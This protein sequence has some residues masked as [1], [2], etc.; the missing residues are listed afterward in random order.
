MRGFSKAAALLSSVYA[1]ASVASNLDVVKSDK[2]PDFIIKYNE[3]DASVVFQISDPIAPGVIIPPLKLQVG[4]TQEP[5][6]QSDIRLGGQTVSSRWIED[7]EIGSGFLDAFGLPNILTVWNISCLDDPSISVNGRP[8]SGDLIQVAQFGIYNHNEGRSESAGFAFSFRSLGRPQ[9]LRV[10]PTWTAYPDIEAHLDDWRTPS[11]AVQPQLPGS[12]EIN[13]AP[14]GDLSQPK[15]K[16]LKVHFDH[17]QNFLGT[18]FDKARQKIGTWCHSHR[19][20]Q[21]ALVPSSGETP[22]AV[23]DEVA[24]TTIAGSSGTNPHAL[25]TRSAGPDPAI[26]LSISESSHYTGLK[27]FGLV[28]IISSVCLWIFLQLRDPRRRADIAARCEERRNKRLYRRAARQQK[29]KRWFCSWRHRN[30]RCTPVSTWDEK[31]ARVIEQ[32]DV[33]ESVMK[34]DILKLRSQHRRESNVNAAEQGRSVY[35]YDSDDSRRRSRE[36]LPGYESEGTQPPSYDQD[37]DGSVT[38]VADG[39]RYINTNREYTPDSSVIST[40]PRTSR[41]ERDSD[42]GKDFE[43]I[44]LSTTAV[45]V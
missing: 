20:I 43:P 39:F 31:R 22:S 26:T 34:E 28:L 33:L 4:S 41:D 36:T 27:I 29:F 13:S 7:H 30:H 11:L 16:G 14:D 18:T 38:R 45:V 6:G 21:S 17:L 15:Q 23:Q 25:P 19:P 3:S 2:A 8:D 40:S 5:C 9:L 44:S 42:Y 1:S 12:E 37:V 10:V 24:T 32:E 35:V